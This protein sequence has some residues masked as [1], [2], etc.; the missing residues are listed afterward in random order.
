MTEQVL[1]LGT[2]GRE[3]ALLHKLRE[4]QEMRTRDPELGS[5]F[6]LHWLADLDPMDFE[7]VIQTCE[8]RGITWVIVG[9]EAPLVAGLADLLQARGI[10]VVGPG[11]KGA[12]LEGSKVF[13]KQF[14]D[15]NQVATAPF[16][17]FERVED[18]LDYL[19]LEE[20]PCVVKY[21]GL[22]GGKGVSVCQNGEEA[23]Q[24]LEELRAMYGENVKF[25][26]EDLLPGEELSLM[27]LV[28]GGK[29]YAFP[30]SQDH[31]QLLDGDLGPNTGGMGA[32]CPVPNL[33]E[34]LQAL[35][36]QKIV[37][38]TLQGFEKE[39]IAYFGFLYF[40]IMVT[41]KG[42][43]L[44]EYNVRLGDPEAE[45]LLTSMESDLLAVLQAAWAGELRPEMLRFRP[46][47]YLDVVLT[48]AGYPK[49]PRKG[50]VIRGLEALPADVWVF[51]SGTRLEEGQYYTQGGR[52]LNVVAQGETL[53][54]AR[55]RAYAAVA[56]LDFEGC[57]YRKDIGRRVNRLL[58]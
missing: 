17:A 48:A 37:A 3:Q 2:G 32:Y 10:K 40:G 51:H 35:I 1:I 42:P 43:F 26:I 50:D 16:A 58:S 18:G 52:V 41:E 23:S 24:A 30:Y 19:M 56:L 29:F 53:E 13:S 57:H 31:K 8:Q 25:I 28:A 11:Q 7:S 33:S 15:R 54:A 39:G 38:P 44:L 4:G 47:F 6:G 27:G 55:E 21:D 22:A 36:E 49:N 14:M 9:P 46:G 5:A 34:D 12:M 45:V 20:G